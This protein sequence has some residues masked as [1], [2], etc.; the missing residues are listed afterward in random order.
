MS[1]AIIINV[2]IKIKLLQIDPNSQF[3]QQSL[4]DRIR[5]TINQN[6]INNTIQYNLLAKSHSVL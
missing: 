3:K 6:Y 2:Q 5:N 1:V 4:T